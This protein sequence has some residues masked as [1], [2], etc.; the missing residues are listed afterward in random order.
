MRVSFRT[1]T[2]IQGV[3]LMT[4]DIT[5]F[6]DVFTRDQYDDAFMRHWSKVVGETHITDD[7]RFTDVIMDLLNNAWATQVS[8][9]GSDLDQAEIYIDDIRSQLPHEF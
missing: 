2:T 8:K 9:L 5:S 7:G 4:P 6:A 1:V 3:G